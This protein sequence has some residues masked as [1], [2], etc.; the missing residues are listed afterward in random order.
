MLFLT[1]IPGMIKKDHVFYDF[2]GT[3]SKEI[4]YTKKL[5]MLCSMHY[6]KSH[7]HLHDVCQ[8]LFVAA[9]GVWEFPPSRL[10]P[11]TQEL[12]VLSPIQ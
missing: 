9:S 7:N 3:V 12:G 2:V 4:L 11:Q 5:D 6:T 8:C 10:D 1:H